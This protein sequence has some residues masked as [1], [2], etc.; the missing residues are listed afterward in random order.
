MN[1]ETSYVDINVLPVV[2]VLAAVAIVFIG[3]IKPFR[4]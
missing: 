1:F 3:F 4:K 2:L